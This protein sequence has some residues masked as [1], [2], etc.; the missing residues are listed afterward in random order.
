MIRICADIKC[1]FFTTETELSISCEGA[2]AAVRNTM[3]FESKEAKLDY[4]KRYCLFY[5][6]NCHIRNAVEEK[7]KNRP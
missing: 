3:K 6:N 4:I 5:P 2:E 7:Y 1:P